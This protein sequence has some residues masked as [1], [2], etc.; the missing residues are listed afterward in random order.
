MRYILV[1][2][3]INGMC[4]ISCSYAARQQMFSCVRTVTYILP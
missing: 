1:K 2:N 3:T 4:D